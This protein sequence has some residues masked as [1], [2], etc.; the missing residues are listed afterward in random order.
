MANIECHW[1]ACKYNKGA[2]KRCSYNGTIKLKNIDINELLESDLTAK[3]RE[4]L[5]ESDKN[6]YLECEQFTL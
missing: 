2:E 6:F 5:D 4:E 1:I 3:R